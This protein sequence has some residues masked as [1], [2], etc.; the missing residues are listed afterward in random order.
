MTSDRKIKA[1]RSNAAHSTGPRTAQ[2]KERA[3]QN[4]RR[5]GLLATVV[6]DSPDGRRLE[7]LAQLVGQ[8]WGTGNALAETVADA[9]LVIVRIR[10]ARAALMEQIGDTTDADG[11][12]EQLRRLDDYERKALSRRQT[13]IRELARLASIARRDI[14]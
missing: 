10:A 6:R 9:E 14:D 4:A 11:I 7:R 3:G 8:D 13:A 5:H 12:L 1:N 2:G